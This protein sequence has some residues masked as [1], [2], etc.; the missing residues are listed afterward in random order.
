MPYEPND[1]FGIT[2]MLFPY[3]L[4]VSGA[5]VFLKTIF[6]LFSNNENKDCLF[7]DII[8]LIADIIHKE[9]Q[10]ILTE[11]EYFT[12]I[13]YGFVAVYY[14]YLFQAGIIPG[15]QL[16]RIV[17][18]ILSISIISLIDFVTFSKF[19]K[20]STRFKVY[21]KHLQFFAYSLCG[22]IFALLI[23]S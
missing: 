2:D 1:R 12:A 9:K 19:A 18:F 14:L 7:I 16:S 20:Q 11:L 10:D 23:F 15:Y 21:R 8:D 22:L 6:I 3:N 17:Y 4:I 13:V 5:I